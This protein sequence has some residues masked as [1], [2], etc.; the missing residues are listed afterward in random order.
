LSSDDETHRR[1]VRAIREE[2]DDDGPR[3][4]Y[5]DWL[6]ERG[7][8]RGE[9]IVQQCELARLPELEPRR[10]DLEA[11]ARAWPGRAEWRK[12]LESLG[13]D[14]FLFEPVRGFYPIVRLD[15]ARL[16][17][18]AA[19]AIF[20][21]EPITGVLLERGVEALAPLA[22]WPG[23][24]MLRELRLA[25]R[26]FDARALS[27]LLRAP[28]LKNLARLNIERVTI[29]PQVIEALATA[30]ALGALRRLYLENVPAGGVAAL[31][32]S[33]TLHLSALRLIASTV[34]K[35]DLRALGESQL[36]APLEE[37]IL[38]RSLEADAIGQL[39]DRFTRLQRL[40]IGV[41]PLRD[42]GVQVLARTKLPHLRELA[43][44]D[45]KLEL[46]GARALAASGALARLER[47]ELGHN[48]LGMDGLREIL[49][50]IG[51]SLRELSLPGMT[52]D[53]PGI[54]LLAGCPALGAL[55]RLDVTGWRLQDEGAQLLA[56]GEHLRELRMLHMDAGLAEVDRGSR[57]Q[58][59]LTERFGIS[60]ERFRAR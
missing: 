23:L 7:D 22:E 33:R 41:C 42:P 5:A 4:V 49:A 38:W 40:T 54:R 60:A 58:E 14:L 32:A 44:V 34:G 3:L 20:A 27:V 35:D 9:A 48:E 25:G 45:V 24:P 39:D 12:R 43:L 17:S 56:S 51:P 19:D 50:A 11:R 8:P 30:P 15:P 59:M 2:P 31:A 6:Q 36:R 18:G 10:L 13:A 1:F 46:P 47:L 21:V 16:I 37:L 55:V 29:G 28:G 52:L 26:E 57:G 53:L